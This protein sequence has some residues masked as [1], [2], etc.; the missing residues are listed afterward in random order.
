MELLFSSFINRQQTDTYISMYV[1][2]I[3]ICWIYLSCSTKYI[4]SG[5]V[6]LSY[7]EN[8]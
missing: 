6:M 4:Y 5:T 2:I 1:H 7:A 8:I 3:E